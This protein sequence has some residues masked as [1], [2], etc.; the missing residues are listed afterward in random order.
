MQGALR[1]GIVRSTLQRIVA[2]VESLA[3]RFA[4]F[5]L[6][7]AVELPWQCQKKLPSRLYW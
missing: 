7:A 2:E 5:K 1:E 6:E 3:G 4:G